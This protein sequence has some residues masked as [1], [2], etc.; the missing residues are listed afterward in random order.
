MTPD[1]IWAIFAAYQQGDVG[2]LAGALATDVVWIVLGHTRRAGE[3]Q[4]QT[5]SPG[6]SSGPKNSAA[7]A[8]SRNF[9]TSL[10][11]DSRFVVRYHA[12]G[13]PADRCRGSRASGAKDMTQRPRRCWTAPSHN[14]GIRG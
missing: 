10:T 3:Y 2:P 14:G 6:S 7:A 4:G 9:S 11:D 1:N 12:I 13:E 5:E 8:T